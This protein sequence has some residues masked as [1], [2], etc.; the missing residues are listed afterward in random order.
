MKV[1]PLTDLILLEEEISLQQEKLTK[2][3]EESVTRAAEVTNYGQ[4]SWM[5][6]IPENVVMERLKL[7]GLINQKHNLEVQLKRRKKK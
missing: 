7:E 5:N 3:E 2:V 6:T 4:Y 1:D